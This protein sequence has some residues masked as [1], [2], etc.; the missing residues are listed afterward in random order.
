MNVMRVNSKGKIMKNSSK[1]NKISKREKRVNI[2]NK[3]PG[4]I[5]YLTSDF[6][7]YSPLITPSSSSTQ[8]DVHETEMEKNETVLGNDGGKLKD[9][10]VKYL[11]SDAY[12]Y[13]P[14]GDIRHRYNALVKNVISSPRVQEVPFT[15]VTSTVLS[16]KIAWQTKQ[17]AQDSV[18]DLAKGGRPDRGAKSPPTPAILDGKKQVTRR[19][20]RDLSKS[21]NY[22]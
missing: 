9:K 12:L 2:F 3:I 8:Y 6:H 22:K 7:F 16:K 14:L 11:K 18:G 20:V 4:I 17:V 15:R 13:A 10:V 19:T 1:R 21:S 5:N